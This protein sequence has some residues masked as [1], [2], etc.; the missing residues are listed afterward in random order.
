[1]E[2][3]KINLE[4]L[5]DIRIIKFGIIGSTGFV[6][7]MSV[8]WIFKEIFGVDQYISHALGFIA[9]VVNN[10]VL[11]KYWTFQDNSVKSVRQFGF[12]FFISLIGMGFNTFFLYV[13]VEFVHINFYLG[14]VLAVMLVFLWNYVSNSILTFSGRKQINN[15]FG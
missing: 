6:I 12:F 7:D 15:N 5:F 14:K 4:K 9:A 8:T 2:K 11:N 13:F 3:I 10:Y 1:M